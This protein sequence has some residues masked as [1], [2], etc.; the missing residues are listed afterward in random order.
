MKLKTTIKMTFWSPDLKR[1]PFAL[2]LI[3]EIKT[4]NNKK[5][6]SQARSD[7]TVSLFITSPWIKAFLEHQTVN[8]N[9]S[10]EWIKVL[11][12][13]VK[14]SRT[15][16]SRGLIWWITR[17]NRMD[18]CRVIYL[19]SRL[20]CIELRKFRCTSRIKKPEKTNLWLCR[21]LVWRHSNNKVTTCI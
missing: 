20:I 6:K 9:K 18:G 17:V 2:F 13:Q 14:K 8:K 12:G 5:K 21:L 19:M 4:N 11:S 7:E 16:N 3:E 10:Q 1:N 15:T